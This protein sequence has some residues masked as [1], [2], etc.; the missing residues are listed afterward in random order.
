MRAWTRDQQNA[1]WRKWY[2][3]NAQR[4][5]SWQ[6]R[7]REEIRAWFAELKSGREC[8]RCGERRPHCL[9]FHHVDAED[10]DTE[11]ATAVGYG[12]SRERIIAEVAKC[13]VLCANCHLKHHWK[14]RGRK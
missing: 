10:K 4:K 1:A 13:I 12:F 7:R 9:Q 2:S 5:M 11:V 14:A 8:E 3:A 6:Q